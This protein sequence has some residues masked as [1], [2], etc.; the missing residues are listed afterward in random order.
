MA[1]FELLKLVW[2]LFVAE[3]AV[4]VY[5]IC[6]IWREGVRNLG[7]WAWT[8]I[9]ALISLFG[10]IAFLIFGRVSAWHRSS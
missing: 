5:C 4:R 8:F 3:I 1:A 10:W 2:P 9:V 7:K 6:L